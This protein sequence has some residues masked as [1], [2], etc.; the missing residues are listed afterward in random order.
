MMVRREYEKKGKFLPRSFWNLP[1][2]KPK[3]QYQCR[4]AAKLLRTYDSEVISTVLDKEKWCFSLSAKSLANLF[5]V[6]QKRRDLQKELGKMLE[7]ESTEHL[8]VND[9]PKFRKRE[10]K[11]FTDG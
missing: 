1:E 8:P 5:D 11:T 7:C 2:Y 10:K 3:Y 6:E 9:A 4:L